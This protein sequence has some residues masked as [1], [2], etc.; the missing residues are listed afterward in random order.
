MSLTEAMAAQL[1]VIAYNNGGLPEVVKDGYNGRL[2]S[3]DNIAELATKI[4]EIYNLT[5]TE[6]ERLG[7]NGEILAKE[8]VDLNVTAVTKLEAIKTVFKISAG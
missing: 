2:V 4:G 6:R 7:K 3:L 1:P 8:T 5:A